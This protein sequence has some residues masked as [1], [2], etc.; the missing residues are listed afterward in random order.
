ML[1]IQMPTRMS[2]RLALGIARLDWGARD[3]ENASP[4]ALLA[5]DFVRCTAD[6]LD[7]YVVPNN[8]DPEPR[9]KLPGAFSVW[10]RQ[11]DSAITVFALCYG[12]EH[13]KHMRRCIELLQHRHETDQEGYPFSFCRRTWEELM[14]VY[15]EYIREQRREL[16]RL[17]RNE[18][19]RLEDLRLLAFTPVRGAA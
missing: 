3:A 4:S 1:R 12:H 13:E 15:C 11:V 17:S 9:P 19:P 2:N 5:E 10:K 14:C 8:F 6:Q 16:C 18:N 7:E